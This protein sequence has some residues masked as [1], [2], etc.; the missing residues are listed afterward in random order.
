MSQ[1]AGALDA[2]ACALNTWPY[3]HVPGGVKVSV[4]YNYTAAEACGAM[5][6]G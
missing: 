3:Y 5:G 6:A 2:T 1:G 4:A